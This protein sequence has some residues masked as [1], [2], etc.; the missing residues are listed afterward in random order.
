MRKFYSRNTWLVVALL[1]TS[2]LFGGCQ[3]DI[4]GDAST[5]TLSP[6]TIRFAAV[7]D[8][9]PLLP[10]KTYKNAFGEEYTVSAF[11][12]YIHGIEFL[13]SRSNIVTSTDKN[14][15]FLVNAIDPVSSSIVVKVPVGEYDGMR[16]LIGVDSIRNVS[17]AQTGALDPA[18]GMQ[19]VQWI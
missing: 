10:G 18:Q 12:F 7:V 8:A 11:R 19:E 16:F 5:T 6:V 17:G 4:S 1:A 3:K 9:D 2:F 13:N 14:D 15:H